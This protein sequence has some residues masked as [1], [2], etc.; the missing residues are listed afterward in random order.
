[1]T[2]RC[3]SVAA[4]GLRVV[5]R[6][7]HDGDTL[8]L[9]AALL[10]WTDVSCL[11]GEHALALLDVLCGYLSASASAGPPARPPMSLFSPIVSRPRHSH[12]VAAAV[13]FGIAPQSALGD[14]YS[15][16]SD[17]QRACA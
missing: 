9:G 1:M 11:S 10:I 4:V 15:I 16:M 8:R 17:G 5:A 2:T 14:W 6:A 3:Y 7:I 12:R 13:L